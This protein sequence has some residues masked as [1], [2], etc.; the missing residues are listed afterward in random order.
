[1][2]TKTFGADLKTG[3]DYI[4]EI[5]S[6]VEVEFPIAISV[7]G[8]KIVNASYETEWKTGSTNPVEKTDKEGNVTIEYEENYTKHKLTA[9]EIKTIDAW[10]EHQVNS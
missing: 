4:K 9:D 8:G 3:D 5:Y 2:A 10:L 1:M 7:A 6:L